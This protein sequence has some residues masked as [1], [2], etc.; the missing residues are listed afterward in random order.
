[1]RGPRRWR[2]AVAALI[3]GVGMAGA[4]AGLQTV[5][6]ARP[7]ALAGIVMCGSLGWLVWREWRRRVASR[8]RKSVV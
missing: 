2:W 7:G 4:L 3:V 1:M 8:D 5:G 6:F